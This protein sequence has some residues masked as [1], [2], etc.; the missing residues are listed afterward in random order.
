LGEWLSEATGCF[1]RLPTHAEWKS[2]VGSQIYPW[3]NYWPPKPTDGN[4]SVH[5]DGSH[6]PNGEAD[7]FVGTAP[8]Q[9]YHPNHLGFFDLG[10]NVAEWVRE[11]LT[12]VKYAAVGAGWNE[13]GDNQMKLSAKLTLLKGHTRQYV[14]FRLLKDMQIR[15]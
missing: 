15:R 13:R 1:W 6:D 10:G 3:G 14:G 7:G 11:S 9:S 12:E 8:V 5:A 2:A 4:F